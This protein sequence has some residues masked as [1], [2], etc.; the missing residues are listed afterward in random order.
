MTPGLEPASPLLERCFFFDAVEASYPIT[1]VEGKV[2]AWLRGAYYINGPAKFERAGQRYRHWLDGDGMVCTVR[3]TDEGI[4][5][6]NRFVRT[7]KFCREE[8][9]G[10]FLYRAFGTAFPGDLLRRGI[11]LQP[12]LN[13]SVYPLDGRLL[14]FGEQS[15][16]CELDPLTLE[17]RGEYDFHGALN[18]VSPFSAHPKFDGRMVNFGLSYSAAKPM[19]NVYEF[20]AGG[21]LLQRLRWELD[22]PYS[23]HDFAIS[24]RAAVFFLGPLLMDVDHFRQ[25]ASVMESLQWSPE[26]GSRILVAPRQNGGDPFLVEAGSGYCLH[27]INCYEEGDRLTVDLLELDGPV[28]PD[29]QPLPE[30]F[31]GT[32]GCRPVRYLI[33]CRAR[34]LADRIAMPY[35]RIADFPSID[36]SQT[37]TRHNDFWMLGIS[38]TVQPGCKFFDELVRG[39]WQDGGIAEF[40]RVPAGE[41]LSGEP[42]YVANPREP[43][44][45]LVMVQ[46][47][48]PARQRTSFLLFDAHGINRGPVARLPL[49]HPL[50]PGFHATFM[51]G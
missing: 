7:P 26:R 42:V 8:Q 28:Y 35:D 37:G 21:H 36:P 17:T 46:Q 23:L 25:G 19:L 15:I 41:F 1:S 43:G 14:A 16:P 5:F 6:A 50:P 10:R 13:V 38:R 30:L 2:P 22:L 39:S 32:T 45:A 47:L 4:F 18:E 20:D 24:P 11:M 31:T 27:L 40:Y 33:D 34:K 12:P 29:Y 44:E 48:E 51:A 9:A 3:F 49:K